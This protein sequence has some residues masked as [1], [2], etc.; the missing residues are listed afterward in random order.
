MKTKIYFICTDN[1]KP[2]GGVKQLYRQVDLLNANGYNATILHKKKGFRCTWFKNETVVES[3]KSIFNQLKFFD[4]KNISYLG[5]LILKTK[6]RFGKKIEENSI[7]VFPEIYGPNICF[8]ESNNKKVIF[9]QNC[10]YTFDKYAIDTILEKSPYSKEHN[11]ATI[12]VSNDS[13]EYLKFIFPDLN[14]FRIRLGIDNSIFSYSDQK[15]KQIAF[16]PRKLSED[17]IQVINI[18]N[19][20]KKC[21][22]WEFVSIENKSETEV[23]EI[24]KKSMIFLSFNYR[25]GFGLPPVEAMAC[26]NVVVGYHGQGGKEFFED[27]FN[28]LVQDRNIIEFVEKVEIAVSEY[29]KNPILFIQKG[30]NA[31][32]FVLENYSLVKEKE[33]ILKIWKDLIF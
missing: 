10:Y 8:V 1:S 26:G 32:D 13:E 30:K 25:E 31:S 29:N 21:I 24:L 23:S 17:V 14:L 11:L 16:M 27:K 5:K 33:D 6:I 20:R 3:N 22:G 15:N 28:Y 18:L 2:A 4:K 12:V 19:Q 9:N 7:L